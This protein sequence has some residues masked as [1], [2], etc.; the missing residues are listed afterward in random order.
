MPWQSSLTALMPGRLLG[1]NKFPGVQPVGVGEVWCRACTKTVL[2]VAGEEAKELCGINQL[3]ANME[4]GIEGEIHVITELWQQMKEEEDWGFLLIDGSN[5][6]H[7]MNWTAMLWPDKCGLQ[8]R[9]THS[10]A[11]STGASS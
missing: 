7:E 8:G 2:L 10:T 11:I 3:C 1:L 9:N 6:F 4:V 5:A